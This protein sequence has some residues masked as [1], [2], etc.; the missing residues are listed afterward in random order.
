MPIDIRVRVQTIPL[1]V[2]KMMG[3]LRTYVS[4]TMEDAVLPS[5]VSRWSVAGDSTAIAVVALVLVLIHIL[6]ESLKLQLILQYNSPTIYA[7]YTTHL[8]HESASHLQGNLV[9]YLAVVPLTYAMCLRAGRHREFRIAFLTILFVLPPVI[10]LVSL[11]GLDMVVEALF[12]FDPN[13]EAGRGFSALAGAFVG[14]LTVAV[15]DLLRTA[16]DHDGSLWPSVSLLFSIGLTDG[17]LSVFKY[18]RHPL[19]LLLVALPFMCAVWLLSRVE[20]AYCISAGLDSGGWLRGQ[21]LVGG[22]LLFGSFVASWS[23]QGLLSFPPFEDGTNTLSHFV[24]LMLGIGS[25]ILIWHRTEG[26]SQIA[27]RQP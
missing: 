1:Y 21:Y 11:F 8:V 13:V 25:G 26:L 10:S 9:S 20:R 24:G 6:P 5:R 23:V 14:V 27:T 19:A 16:S 18:T 22:F 2:S 12:G 3:R 17:L 15:A 7:L 4:Q